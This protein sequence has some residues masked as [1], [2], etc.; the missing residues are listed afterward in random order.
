MSTY[1]DM[2]PESPQEGVQDLRN[3]VLSR[4]YFDGVNSVETDEAEPNIRIATEEP[5]NELIHRIEYLAGVNGYTVEGLVGQAVVWY[6]DYSQTHIRI[7][8]GDTVTSQSVTP[9]GDT[10]EPRELNDQAAQ[11]V[12]GYIKL[13]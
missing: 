5:D 11:I 10:T 2:Y 3:F 4:A 12:L 13:N 1:F 7:H 9:A 8:E 6:A